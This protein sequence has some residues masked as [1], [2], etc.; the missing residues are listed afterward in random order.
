MT[1]PSGRGKKGEEVSR[2]PIDD[3]LLATKQHQNVSIAVYQSNSLLVEAS[4]LT[5]FKEE[6]L[7]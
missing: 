1:R 5:F 2:P 7:L 6:P 3:I 4:R